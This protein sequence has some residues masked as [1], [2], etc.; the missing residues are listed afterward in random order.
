MT[1]NERILRHLQDGN[2]ITQGEAF[3]EYGISRLASR[4]CDLGKMGFVIQ[5]RRIT[6][7]NRYGEKVSFSEYWMEDGK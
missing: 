4:I 2:R 7:K 5:R 3:Y 6:R 1:Q